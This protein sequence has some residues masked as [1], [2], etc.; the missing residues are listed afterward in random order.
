MK[1]RLLVL[2]L[3]YAAYM[4]HSGVKSGIIDNRPPPYPVQ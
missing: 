4:E 2:A 1:S 3:G